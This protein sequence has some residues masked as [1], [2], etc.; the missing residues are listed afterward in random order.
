[1]SELP[2]GLY[3]LDEFGN[4]VGVGSPGP[5]GPAGRDGVD[6][7]PGAPGSPGIVDLHHGSDPAVARPNVPIVYWIGTATPTNARPWDLWLK[8]NV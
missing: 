4:L 5:R 6:G 8:E 3:T 2:G 1:M 7:A